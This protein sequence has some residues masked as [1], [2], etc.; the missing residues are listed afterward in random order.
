MSD[1]LW[2]LRT[3]RARRHC[4]WDWDET[5]GTNIGMQVTY[6]C[7]DSNKQVANMKDSS[8]GILNSLTVTCLFNGNY[9]LNVFDWTCTDCLERP[10]PPNSHLWCES[11]R[12]EVGS[13]CAL[14]CDPGY[15]PLGK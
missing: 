10:D 5:V 2:D 11:N 14:T 4:F 8:F 3:S 13:T 6:T 9:D 12:L 15:I 1:G 7:L